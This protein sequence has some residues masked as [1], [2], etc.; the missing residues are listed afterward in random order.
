MEIKMSDSSKPIVLVTGAT[1]KQG[2]ATVRQLLAGS[3]TRVRALTRSPDSPK[4]RALAAQGVEVI[5][6]DLSDPSSTRAALKG[7]SAAFSVQT[8]EGKRGIEA[9]MHRGKAFADAVKDAGNLHLVYSSVDGAERHSGVPH[10]ESKWRVEQHIRSLGLSATILRPVAFMEN[11]ATGGISRAMFLGMLKA[12]IGMNRPLQLVS[13]ADIGWFAA[14]ALETPEAYAGRQIA[15]AG[16]ELTLAEIVEI[17]R[18]VTGG[19]PAIAPLPRFAPRLMLP[20]DIYLM[21][22]W[23]AAAGYEADLAAIR[24]KHP[25]VL[26]FD[27]WLRSQASIS[28]LLGNG[29][30]DRKAGPAA[31]AGS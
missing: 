13:V 5:R 19:A 3:R 27:G 12:T 14:R 24:A 8:F 15:V 1:G 25:G 22:R 11:F 6:G 4:A 21:L 18:R 10:F 26:S 9:E 28:R 2:G 23:F 17:Y 30:P 29:H 20:K 7:V 31:V 16:D